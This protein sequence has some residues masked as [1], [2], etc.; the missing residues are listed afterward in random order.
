M[1]KILISSATLIFCLTAC[2]QLKQMANFSKCEFR[3]NNVQNTTLAGVNVQQVQSVSDL[4]LLDAGRL[5]A[6]YASGSMPLSLTVNL[7]V[8]NPN[9]ATA[10]M[11]RLEWILLIE[12]KEIVNGI[13]ND[14]VSIAPNGVAQLP[15]RISTDLRKL[16]AKNTTQENINLG[17][18]LVGGGNK[19]SKKLSLKVKPSIV[20]GSLTIPYPGYL[21][22]GTNF[23][24]GKN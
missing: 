14:R 9:N 8:N 24:A 20:I 18:G 6:A 4:N 1:K 22:V 11:N 5:S 21:T 17:L 23:G 13:V 15:L 12:D 19:P 7:D 3:M 16:M 2:Q 10:A